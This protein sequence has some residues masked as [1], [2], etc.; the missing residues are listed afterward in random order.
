MLLSI[1]VSV[2]V[3]TT[4]SMSGLRGVSILGP[5]VIRRTGNDQGSCWDR[6]G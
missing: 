2:L 1:D 5:N 3:N 4:A 6:L